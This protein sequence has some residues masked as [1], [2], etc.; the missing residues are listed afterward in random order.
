MIIGESV[1]ISSGDETVAAIF[2]YVEFLKDNILK[3]S[4]RFLYISLCSF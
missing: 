4:L 3:A 1:A 2:T